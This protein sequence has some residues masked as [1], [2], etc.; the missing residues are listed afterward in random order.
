MSPRLTAAFLYLCAAMSL[1][2]ALLARWE[3]PFYSFDSVWDGTVRLAVQ[4]SPFVFICTSILVFFRS[5]VGYSMGLAAGLIALPWF[6]VTEL[7]WASWNSWI[8]LN[9]EDPIPSGGGGYVT[10]VKLKI[11]S[12]ALIVIA[13]AVSSFRLLPDRWSLR[14]THLCQRTWPAFAVGSL[15]LAVWF[16]HSVT[17]YSVP[18]YDHPAGAQ[19]RILHVRKRGPWFHETS[20]LG[21]RNGRV[22]MWRQDR[23]LF[24]Y[25]IAGRGAMTILGQVSP[26]AFERA[27][28]FV[29]SSELWKLRTAPP[30]ALR[31]WNAEGWY[32]VLKDS[33]LLAFTTEF[34]TT[35]PDEVTDLFNELQKLPALEERPFAVRDVCLGFCYDPV[36][37]LGFSILPQRK[38]LLSGSASSER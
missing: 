9:Y 5:R 8:F 14:G 23:H 35:P 19:F 2:S 33:R 22:F 36:A 7:S 32:V 38:R 25:R 26:T 34:G 37:A 10:F 29:E 17:P 13:A 31:A 12:A 21:L 1:A 16:A 30:K 24:Q 3:G 18:G 11:L 27:R 15:M 4:A 6:V 28:N 20:I